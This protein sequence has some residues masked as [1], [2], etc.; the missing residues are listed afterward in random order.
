MISKYS[1]DDLTEVW[2]VP[3]RLSLWMSVELAACAAME[4]HGI[5]PA[6]T[7]ASVRSATSG[8]L[9]PVRVAEIEQTTRHDFI[10]FLAH[11]EEIA[12]E[13]ARWIHRGMTSSD[14][15]DTALALQMREASELLIARIMKFE[16]ALA[17]RAREHASTPTMGRS[18]GMHAEPTTV[19]FILAGHHAEIL[20]ATDRFVTAIDGISVGK[21]SGAVGNYS[22]LPPEIERQVMEALELRPEFVSTQ[23][24]ARD[25][26]AFWIQSIALIAC[27]IERLALTIR[28][29]QRTE[30][31]EAEEGFA[32]GQK[33]SSAMPHKRNPIVS[34]NLC[35]LS[36][37]I[38]SYCGP[39][40]EDISLWHERD[41]SH[42][43]V[44]RVIIP[45]AS[46][47]LG[48]MLD[49][50]IYLIDNLVFFPD[51]MQRNIQSSGGLWA[52]ES[53]LLALIDAGCPRQ[54]AYEVVQK[55][56]MESINQ[57]VTSY[58]FQQL[59]DSNPYIKSKIGD[60]LDRLF[61]VSSVVS[62][63][64]DLVEIALR[65]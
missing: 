56:A 21:L 17:K 60:K 13:P 25:R 3:H 44:E 30:V 34:E 38:R 64:P 14:V 22:H 59:L 4:K 42:S 54:E 53:V 10:A 6:G 24:V 40:L 36:R 43:S 61:N 29:W 37:L 63:I 41:I 55:I 9:N 19:G 62:H 2:G 39:A 1:P 16:I 49:R 50:A 52:S 27:A 7:E 58:T 46:C 15:V 57:R 20:R 65:H 18:H 31:G 8:K 33:G 12:G 48:Y 45:D 32:S 5:V 47:A 11:V 35:G 23:V 51:R 28:H 26:H